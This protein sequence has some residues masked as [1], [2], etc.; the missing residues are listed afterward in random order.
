M[1]SRYTLYG[2]EPSPFSG[3]V[4]A[5]LRFKDLDWIE[6]QAS[7]ETYQD[8][9]VPQIGV[10]VIP[11]LETADGQYVQDSTDIIDFLEAR[12]PQVS[13]YPS[14]PL[15]KLVALLLEFYGDEWLI[16][17][18]MHYRWTVLDQQYDFMMSEF[19]R[20]FAP[21]ASPEEQ[22]AIGEEQSKQFQGFSEMVGVTPETIPGIEKAYLLLLEQLERH[23]EK[24]DYLLGSRPGICDYGFICFL[25]AML[26]RD[27]VPKALMQEKAPKVY[28]WVQRMNHP[29]PLSGEFL[30]EDE[31]PATLIPVLKTMCQDHLPDVL[32]VIEHNAAWLTENPGGN[33]PRFLGMHDFSTGGAS[34]ER[35]IHSYAQWMFQRPL[36]HYQAL[37]G[38]DKQRAD[39]LLQSIGGYD[40]LNVRI[41]HRVKRKAGQLE[42]VEDNG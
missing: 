11:V 4:R 33:L 5:Y 17:P 38:A 12:H 1:I 15:Q 34:G 16:V 27:P 37:V 10:P 3:K 20:L 42:L 29:T 21:D 32:G 26:G 6:K 13:I 30:A 7:L 28:A 22:F 40:A 2:G 9:I 39:D 24:Y 19:G 35:L 14:T 18:A 31:I 23:F 8:I 25:Y 36:E 41:K